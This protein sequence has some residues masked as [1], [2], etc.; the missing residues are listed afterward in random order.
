MWAGVRSVHPL[1]TRA[2]TVMGADRLAL[3][4]KVI[5]PASL[6]YIIA[7]T[8]LSVGRAWIG[9]IGGE[10]LASPAYGLGQVIFNAKE[11]L[12]AGVMLSALIVI[13]LIGVATER[14]IFNTLE[15]ATIRKW[16]MAAS[17]RR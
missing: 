1:W 6:P 5:L 16:G 13:G 8:R 3:W 17:A 15:E 2:A 11:F 10:M 12:N 4:R 9:V 14:L 7:G